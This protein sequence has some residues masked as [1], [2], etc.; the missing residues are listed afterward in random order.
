MW[1]AR[2]ESSMGWESAGW[3]KIKAKKAYKIPMWKN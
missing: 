2:E 1:Q 3:G